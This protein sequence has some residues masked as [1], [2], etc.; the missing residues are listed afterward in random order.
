LVKRSGKE[1]WRSNIDQTRLDK[2]GR[3]TSRRKWPE[4][5]NQ[6]GTGKRWKG[7]KSN[8]ETK[9]DRNKVA[10][11]WRVDN[12]RRD[13]NKEEMSIHIRERAERRSNM[14]VLWYFS[15]GV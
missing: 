10:Q 4:K 6:E 3:N 5:K 8:R 15:R 7:N 14:P 1:Q 9:K 2:K 13:S 11:E 12:R